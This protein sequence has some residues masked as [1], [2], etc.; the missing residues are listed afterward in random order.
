VTIAEAIQRQG[1]SGPK[2]A[3]PKIKELP[4][5]LIVRSQVRLPVGNDDEFTPFDFD[6][7]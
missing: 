3:Q 1:G 4:E 7:L 6:D 2:A 5:K